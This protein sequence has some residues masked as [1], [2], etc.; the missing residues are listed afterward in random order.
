MPNMLPFLHD[1]PLR[2]MRLDYHKRTYAEYVKVGCGIDL[3]TR[4]T[5]NENEIIFPAPVAK[6][7]VNQRYLALNDRTQP[8]SMGVYFKLFKHPLLV[9][10]VIY[11]EY[12]HYGG[13]SG[14]PMHGISSET[15]VL[16][17]E[18]LFARSLMNRLAPVDDAGIPDFEKQIVTMAI[19]VGFSGFMAQITTDPMND[20]DLVEINNETLRAYSGRLSPEEVQSSIDRWIVA[21][22]VGIALENDTQN[23]CP[24]VKWPTISDTGPTSNL[25]YQCRSALKRRLQRDHVVRGPQRDIIVQEKLRRKE[26]QDWLNYCR[27]AHALETVGMFGAHP[28]WLVWRF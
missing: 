25:A 2:L 21:E 1:Y 15:D 6:G 5:P 27:R 4:Y 12:L 9:L 11:H 13:P 22:N 16:I 18:I 26:I 7:T 19:E 28:K 8:N 17:R 3:W 24:D 14:D 10:P 23:W 20:D